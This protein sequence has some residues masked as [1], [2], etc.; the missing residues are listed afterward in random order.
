MTYYLSRGFEFNVQSGR[1]EFLPDPLWLAAKYGGFKDTNRNGY[2]DPGEWER[3]PA[4]PGAGPANYYQIAN[5]NEL[6]GQ[7]GKVF[8]GITQGLAFGTGTAASLVSDPAGGLSIQTVFYPSYTV[9]FGTGPV[10]YIGSVFSLFLDPW[11]NL[12]EDT[13]GDRRLT[14]KASGGKGDRIVTF[15]TVAQPP[16]NPPPCYVKGRY[17]TLCDDP[18][19]DNRPV[20]TRTGDPH[21]KAVYH[22]KPVWDAARWLL[23]LD[24]LSGAKLTAGPRDWKVPATRSLGRRRIYYGHRG[25]DNRTTMRLFATGQHKRQVAEMVLHDNY[26]EYLPGSGGRDAAVDTLIQWITGKEFA[27]LRQRKVQNPWTP[28]W[29]AIWRLG[30]VINSKPIVVGPPSAHYDMLYY[31]STYRQFKA[32]WSGRR[33]MAYFGANDGMLHA[34]NMGFSGVGKDGTVSYVASRPGKP[35]LAHDLGAEL[36]AYIPMSL[37]PHLGFLAD[38]SYL[39]VYYVDMKPLVTDLKYDGEWR[40][41]LIGGLRMGGR[42]IEPGSGDLQPGRAYYSEVFCLDVTDP[43]SEPRLMWTYS[44]PELGLMV[45]MPVVVR[46]RGNWYVMLPS[47]PSTDSVTQKGP[48]EVQVNFGG[49]PP[50]LGV[51]NRSARIIVL[52]AED[53]TPVVDP[54]TDP[55]YLRAPVGDSFFGNPFMPRGT[56]TTRWDG[57][58]NHAVYYGLTE[59]SLHGQGSDGG[60][61][62][63]VEMVDSS[64]TPLPPES[65]RLRRLLDTGRPVTGA[66]NST[67]DSRGNLWVIFGTGRLFGMEDVEPCRLAETAECSENHDQYLIGVKEPLNADGLMTFADVT[68]DAGRILDVTGAMVL[69]SG[70]VTGLAQQPGLAAGAGGSMPYVALEAAVKGPGFSGWKRRLDAIQQRTGK[71]GRLHEMVL[72]QPKLMAMGGGRSLMTVSSFEPGRNPCEGYGSGYMYAV[73]TYTGL[74]RPETHYMFKAPPAS[75]GVS[76]ETVTGVVSLGVGNP[77][78][79]SILMSRGRM[80]FRAAA[81]DGGV[82]DLEYV[83][84]PGTMRGLISW[85]EVTDVGLL[86]SREAMTEGLD[87]K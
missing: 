6:Q 16:E 43:E 38:P 32:R 61:L 23:E 21:P 85:R 9:P 37:M 55:D 14:L 41:F 5:A 73:D 10:K 4:D 31:D 11:G 35:G 86:L 45:G 2:P 68:P 39:H 78:E 3:D 87:G 57:W 24:D 36:W 25:K 58:S 80:I 77:T 79:A 13:D 30:D 64:G 48:R 56:K 12:R 47:G 28:I 27:S 74:P 66:V 7:L 83:D 60:G 44:S 81:S 52:D 49:R 70:T 67:R 8:K 84:A 51:S 71:E 50:Y 69:K 59:T 26:L 33:Q 1:P 18:D 53:G 15:S 17:I 82:T 76:P 40:T 65:W 46:S 22:V 34:I 75:S 29:N 72:T 54:E 63:R 19:G 62:W 20:V 42:P